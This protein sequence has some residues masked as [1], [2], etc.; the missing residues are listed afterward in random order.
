VRAGRSVG[1]VCARRSLAKDEEVL[2]YVGEEGEEYVWES[3]ERAFELL[4]VRGCSPERVRELL[5]ARVE[6]SALGTVRESLRG[7]V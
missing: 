5:R 1:V 2:R 6:G 3:I 4:R 7:R